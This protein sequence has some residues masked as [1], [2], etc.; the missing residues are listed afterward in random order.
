MLDIKNMEIKFILEDKI[1][2]FRARY[3][4]DNNIASDSTIARDLKKYND[5]FPKAY[6]SILNN[7]IKYSK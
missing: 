7:V 4:I 3:E 2:E 6:N 1:D 5:D